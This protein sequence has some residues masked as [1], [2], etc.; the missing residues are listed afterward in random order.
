MLKNCDAYIATEVTTQPV[1]LNI[2]LNI[3]ILYAATGHR[4]L[5]LQAMKPKTSW[6]T[7]RMMLL[8]FGLGCRNVTK[9]CSKRI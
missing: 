2:I 3:R 9:I 7:W 5:F 1:I 6:Q 4:W 8:Y